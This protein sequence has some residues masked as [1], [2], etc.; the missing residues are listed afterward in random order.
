MNPWW[1]IRA[2]T[3]VSTPKSKP[4]SKLPTST[5][6]ILILKVRCFVQQ[7]TIKTSFPSAHPANTYRIHIIQLEVDK[8][9]NF[10]VGTPITGQSTYKN[11]YR[12]RNGRPSAVVIKQDMMPVQNNLAFLGRSSY[13]SDYR[14]PKKDQYPS[15]VYDP[16]TLNATLG[17]LN[18]C[19]LNITQKQHTASNTTTHTSLCVLLKCRNGGRCML[20]SIADRTFTSLLLIYHPI[21]VLRHHVLLPFQDY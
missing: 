19:K 9:L 11:N 12:W 18:G 10:P 17:A 8:G 7:P 2:T 3:A 5:K 20:S 1:S 6:T 13:Q 14:A 4:K 16:H 21:T 15:R